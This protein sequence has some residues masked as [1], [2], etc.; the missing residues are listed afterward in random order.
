M[1]IARIFFAVV[2]QYL[3]KIEMYIFISL[4]GIYHTKI[5]TPVSKDIWSRMLPAAIHI[6]FI[7]VFTFSVYM[8]ISLSSPLF[9]NFL[10][11]KRCLHFSLW[12]ALLS[13]VYQNRPKKLI[14]NVS[15]YL[16]GWVGWS[17]FLALDFFMCFR[18]LDDRLIMAESFCFCIVRCVSLSPFL[19]GGLSFVVA[20]TVP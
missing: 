2:W 4:L 13:S 12:A 3:L 17:S 5:K 15:L 20:S 19:S 7:L 18:I 8:L 6:V 11:V 9:Q 16:S 14:S 1:W 10:F